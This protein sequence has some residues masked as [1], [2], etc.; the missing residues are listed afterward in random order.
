[1][2]SNV[3]IS[4]HRRGFMTL[5]S[6]G[7]KLTENEAESIKIAVKDTDI[8]AIHPE[9]MEA[10]AHMLVQKLKSGQHSEK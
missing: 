6:D 7:K 10:L 2:N 8:R 4:K 3:R 9:K 5:P 1:M